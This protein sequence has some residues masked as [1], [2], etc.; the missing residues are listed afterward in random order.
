MSRLHEYVTKHSTRVR[1]YGLL[2]IA[3]GNDSKKEIE[4]DDQNSF[5]PEGEHISLVLGSQGYE[6]MSLVVFGRVG[7]NIS[8]A[9]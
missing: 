3:I 9:L 4:H 2:D 6:D 5:K 7:E 1:E 8:L